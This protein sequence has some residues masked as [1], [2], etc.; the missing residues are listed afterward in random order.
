MAPQS[1]VPRNL[2]PGTESS[3]QTPLGTLARS[4]SGGSGN[5]LQKLRGLGQLKEGL[6]LE[7]EQA[8]HPWTWGRGGQEV[9]NYGKTPPPPPTLNSAHK[10]PER[11]PD[12]TVG[13]GVFANI[14]RGTG[15]H[16]HMDS[17]QGPPE[18][19]TEAGGWQEVPGQGPQLCGRQAAPVPGR[20]SQRRHRTQPG[21][22]ETG[23][24]GPSVPSPCA[25]PPT[26]GEHVSFLDT[27]SRE[28]HSQTGMTPRPEDPPAPADS[29]RVS[30]EAPGR[31][32]GSQE[33]H[34]PWTHSP[35]ATR[36]RSPEG[37]SSPWG[38]D[39]DPEQEWRPPRQGTTAGEAPGSQARERRLCARKPLG[40]AWAAGSC[41][42]P[43]GLETPGCS[44]AAPLGPSMEPVS[45]GG[46]R[47]V[48]VGAWAGT[49]SGC[50]R[51]CARLP[52]RP[53][54]EHSLSEGAGQPGEGGHRPRPGPR[55]P[56]GR[57]SQT[58]S[59]FFPGDQ[60]G[61]LGSGET[62]SQ[63]TA[64]GQVAQ[65]CGGSVGLTVS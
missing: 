27:V 47:S 12:I 44:G 61:H 59:L 4:P 6:R 52:N 33:E 18:A 46:R 56:H 48:Q 65:E 8:G 54:G 15:C 21:L 45:L 60:A 62:G 40:P 28:G 34:H 26:K 37:T 2:W 41:C 50:C 35:T 31:Q 20:I 10:G 16:R 49:G 53:L 19:R 51:D 42:G 3:T 14:R 38:Q 24:V 9:G 39:L 63:R 1:A 58:S 43:R 5:L 25:W 17:L 36:A 11:P 57:E 7:T 22:P 23:V 30:G 29:S 32:G 55:G 64:S 13:A